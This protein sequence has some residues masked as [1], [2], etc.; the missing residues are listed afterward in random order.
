[1]QLKHITIAYVTVGMMSNVFV[2]F[3]VQMLHL[4]RASIQNGSQNAIKKC[5]HYCTCDGWYA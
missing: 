4:S 3:G 1:M 2:L 5:Y